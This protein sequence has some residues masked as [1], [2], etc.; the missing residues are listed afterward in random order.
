[1]RANIQWAY[2][3]ITPTRSSLIPVIGDVLVSPKKCLII[4]M[5]NVCILSYT[6]RALTVT[7]SPPFGSVISKRG[8]SRGGQKRKENTSA[9]PVAAW[10]AS[11]NG[12]TEESGWEIRNRER[13]LEYY[14]KVFMM[15]TISRY[16][17]SN[18]SCIL[19]KT[20]HAPLEGHIWRYFR[21]NSTY[22]CPFKETTIHT[23]FY[24]M[25][26]TSIH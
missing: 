17:T 20:R 13:R 21:M 11:Q 7:I 16:H 12:V 6:K 9:F 19:K 25:P 4:H 1:M 22:Y 2:S 14:S 23:L 3:Q 10:K 5:I 18:Y 8:M 15:A 24:W 26:L